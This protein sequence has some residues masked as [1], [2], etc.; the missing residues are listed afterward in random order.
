MYDFIS[1]TFFI[2]QAKNFSVLL[3][4]MIISM[5]HE[6]EQTP[7]DSEG[8]GAWCAAHHG[9]AKSLA[10]LTKSVERGLSCL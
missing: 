4:S 3:N 7:G 10:G 5:E 6:S 9:A 8:Q 2:A 1:F